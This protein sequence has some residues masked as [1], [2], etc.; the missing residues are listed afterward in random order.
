MSD[1]DFLDDEIYALA[2]TPADKKRKKRASEGK[3]SARKR[4]RTESV[5]KKSFYNYIKAHIVIYSLG[6]SD[7]DESDAEPANPYPL[8]GKY[9]NEEDRRRFVFNLFALLYL[10][11][12]D[13]TANS[14]TN[15]FVDQVGGDA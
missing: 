1:D 6:A 5:S 10:S 3:S 14:M 13:N 12:L 9:K 7:M 4:V 8:E 11:I 2:T 15:T